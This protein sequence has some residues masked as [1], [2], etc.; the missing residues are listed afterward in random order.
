MHTYVIGDIHGCLTE[1]IAL[2]AQL[3]YRPDEDRLLLAGDLV[4]RGPDSLAVLR[5]A[6]KND[7]EMVLGNHDLHL[8]ARVVGINPAFP[9]DQLDELL[10]AED[11][12]NLLDWL[13][14]RPLLI[15]LD[16]HWL[17]HAGLHP[18]WSSEQALELA[19]K[20][21]QRLRDDLGFLAMVLA[22][23]RDQLAF[24]ELT[25][26]DSLAQAARIMCMVRGV[27]EDGSPVM[28]LSSDRERG[29]IHPWYQIGKRS[30]PTVCC[31]HD[32]RHGPYSE[33]GVICVDSACGYGGPLSAYRIEDGN[34]FRSDRR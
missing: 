33:A 26:D 20:A 10:C 19:A 11:L 18:H 14:S 22:E 27:L 23:H 29:A 2:L 34:W 16:S 15:D 1:L 21:S 17:V 6:C 7:V 3:D 12:S 5:W 13:R 25:G 30:F 4:N 24:S 31:G 28:G 9:G 32:A 8:L